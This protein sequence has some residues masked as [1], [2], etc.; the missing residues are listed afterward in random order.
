VHVG[1]FRVE[2]LDNVVN[3]QWVSEPY[4]GPPARRREQRVMP[5]LLTMQ[6]GPL[7]SE[8]QKIGQVDVRDWTS[9]AGL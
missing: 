8:P 5:L 2:F 4:P 9:R 6:L 7:W 1:V 3:R